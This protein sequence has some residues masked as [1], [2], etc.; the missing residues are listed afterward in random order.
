MDDRS[1]R[2]ILLPP[3]EGGTT[4]FSS[5]GSL[6]DRLMGDKKIQSEARAMA[7][8]L[9]LRSR[10][11]GQKPPADPAPSP[12][13]PPVPGGTSTETKGGGRLRSFY[14]RQVR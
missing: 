1:L 3:V 9:V 6:I 14:L 10:D 5:R 4:S 13:P 8:E 11:S 2:G 12:L 7:D